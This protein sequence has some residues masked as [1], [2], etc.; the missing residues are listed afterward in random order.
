MILLA[1]RR[2]LANPMAVTGGQRG[3]QPRA[4]APLGGTSFGQFGRFVRLGLLWVPQTPTLASARPTPTG[5]PTRPTA[6]Q[7]APRSQAGRRGPRPPAVSIAPRDR[8]QLRRR[9]RALTKNHRDVVRAQI[10]LA[11]AQTPCVTATARRLGL[12]PDTVRKWRDR[13]LAHG[14]EGLNDAERTGRPPTIE[15]ASRARLVVLACSLPSDNGVPYRQVWTVDSLRQCYQGLPGVQ[16]MSNSTVSRI[17]RRHELRPHRVRYWLHSPDPRFRDKVSEI[18]DLYLHPQPGWVVLS[19]DEKPGIQAIERRF[20]M[21]SVVVGQ[22]AKFE[23]E[24]IRHGTQTL[25]AALDIHTGHVFRKVARRTG[26]N[27]VAF[28]EEVAT[29]Y[30]GRQVH[31]IWDNLNIHYDGR[32]SRWSRFNE[33]HQNRFHFHYTPLHASWVNQIELFFSI[34]Q[35]RVL[36][37]ASFASRQELAGALVGFIDHWNAYE[38]HAFKWTFCGYRLPC[39]P[40][41]LVG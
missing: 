34:L 29:H 21:R 14:L 28:L 38:R 40:A 10:I 30:P 8:H 15:P 33:R 26:E 24:Y 22:D 25:L 5:A 27:L 4:Q 41:A 32:E 31:V 2:D 6:P 18:C 36:C 17:L 19:V 37:H 7:L 16:P 11:L 3:R 35:R 39:Q 23:F 13:Y 1:T 20:P 12:D 9:A